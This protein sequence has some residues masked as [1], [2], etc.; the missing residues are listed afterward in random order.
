MSTVYE[1]RV[2]GHLDPHWSAHLGGL[3]VCHERDGTSTLTGPLVDQA[4]LHGVLAG[5]RDLGASILLVRALPD[6]CEEVG[7]ASSARSDRVGPPWNG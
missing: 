2:G 3:T 1:L 4:A 5:L 6:G 7:D